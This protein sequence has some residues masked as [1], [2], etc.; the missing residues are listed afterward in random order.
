MTEYLV[1]VRSILEV[2]GG[3]VR[4]Q[5]TF[6]LDVLEVGEERFEL[7]E[8][9]SFDVTISNAGEALV[10]TGHITAHVRA[11]CVRCLCPFETTITGDVEGYWP[12]PGDVVPEDEDVTGEVDGE[13]NIDIAPALLAALV[14]EAPFAPLH[15]EDCAGLCPT[16]GT[17]LNEETCSCAQEAPE[18]SP[19]AKLKGLIPEDSDN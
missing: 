16:C 17:N 3:S 6:D 12:R 7:V 18:N 15:D 5:D 11:Q 19:F 8:P 13:G 10:A 9:A 1:A 4:A 14:V 2:I